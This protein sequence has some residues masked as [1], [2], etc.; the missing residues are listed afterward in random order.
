MWLRIGMVCCQSGVVFSEESIDIIEKV[1]TTN[2]ANAA[3]ETPFANG[4]GI[5]IDDATKCYTP[6]RASSARDSS[7]TQRP[8]PRW[9]CWT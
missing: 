3:L 9:T 5:V 2:T 6:T 4:L 7:T 8:T 1:I